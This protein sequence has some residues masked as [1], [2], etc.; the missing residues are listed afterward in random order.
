[1]ALQQLAP[2]G[3]AA[4]TLYLIQNENDLRTFKDDYS[5]SVWNWIE[6]KVVLLSG[7]F[8]NRFAICR[9][10]CATFF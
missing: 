5:G 4:G 8:F 3:G 9:P 10:F 7:D 1:M 2:E 6:P